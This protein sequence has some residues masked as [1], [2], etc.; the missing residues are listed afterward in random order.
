VELPE[1]VIVAGKG[2]KAL[3]EFVL[4]MTLKEG[5]GSEKTQPGKKRERSRPPA[6]RR[7]GGKETKKRE[8]TPLRVLEEEW[9]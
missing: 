9:T 1:G 8:K 5:G 6:R 4:E 7:R 2:K 3:G